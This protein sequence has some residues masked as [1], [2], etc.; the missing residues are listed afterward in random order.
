MARWR[1]NVTFTLIKCTHLT[2]HLSAAIWNTAT[3]DHTLIRTRLYRTQIWRYVQNKSPSHFCPHVCFFPRGPTIKSKKNRQKT[4]TH[5]H[6]RRVNKCSCGDCL[7]CKTRQKQSGQLEAHPDITWLYSFNLSTMSH[8]EGFVTFAAGA[9]G[10]V[11]FTSHN[12]LEKK[13][14]KKEE[15]EGENLQSSCEDLA[16]L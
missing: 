14:K 12:G 11:L 1:I 9:L 8:V 4:D 5:T 7:I 6:T 13:K 10:A 16:K 3:S 15:G 2:T